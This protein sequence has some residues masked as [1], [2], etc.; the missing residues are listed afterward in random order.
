M[1]ANPVVQ[2]KAG[3]VALL[4]TEDLPASQR[5]S[6]GQLFFAWKIALHVILSWRS[7]SLD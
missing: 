4:Q 5:T 3:Y 6:S 1:P 7:I 2:L